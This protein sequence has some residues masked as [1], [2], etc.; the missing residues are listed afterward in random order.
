MIESKKI[1]AG[2]AAFPLLEIGPHSNEG[3]SLRDWFAGQPLAGTLASGFADTIPHDDVNG[4]ADA[5]FFA[6]QY[7]D[8]MVAARKGGAA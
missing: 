5:A 7:A 3:M 1:N 8:A 6:N 2:G 4:G